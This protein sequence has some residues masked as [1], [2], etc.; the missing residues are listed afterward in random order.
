MPS[1]IGQQGLVIMQSGT[2]MQSG[3][4]GCSLPTGQGSPDSR[5]RGIAAGRWRVDPLERADGHATPADP[6]RQRL[7]DHHDPAT[8]PLDHQQ[9]P[10]VV[11]CPFGRITTIRH[12]MIAGT[13]QDRRCAAKGRRGP[14]PDAP[15]VVDCMITTGREEC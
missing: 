1:G 14:L 4:G 3:N 11:S 10:G 7:S 8:R 5:S 15:I 2:I 12:R 9:A 13:G 6:Q